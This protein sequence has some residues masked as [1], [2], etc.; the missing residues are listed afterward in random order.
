MCER[1]VQRFEDAVLRDHNL[2]VNLSNPESYAEEVLQ[3]GQ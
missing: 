1:P 2:I 3:S